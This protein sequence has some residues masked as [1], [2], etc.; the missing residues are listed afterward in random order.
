VIPGL[1]WFN[2]I[3]RNIPIIKWASTT[4]AVNFNVTPSCFTNTPS[5][6]TLI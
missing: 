1:L 4:I 6:K 2:N 3:A 5:E